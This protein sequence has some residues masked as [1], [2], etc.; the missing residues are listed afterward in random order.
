[1]RAL[2][3]WIRAIARGLALLAGFSLLL[4]ML[5]TVADVIMS[6]VFSSPI[7]GNLDIVSLYHMVLVVFLPLAIVELRHEH[8][9]ADLL[10]RTFPRPLQRAC[11]FF[12][13]LIGVAFFGVLA[14]QTAIDAIEAWKIGEVAMSSVYVPVWPAKFALPIGFAGILLVI[15]M[16]AALALT[17]PEFDPTP[18]APELD[19]NTPAL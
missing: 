10:V 18:A 3:N 5:Q 12:G 2:E 11:Y 4:M 8:I 6:R 7:E 1:M 9:N 19:D 15:L 16:H 13:C 17:D 14:W